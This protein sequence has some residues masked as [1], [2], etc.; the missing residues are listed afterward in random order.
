[1]RDVVD[2]P[3][4]GEDVVFATQER[5]RVAALR[6]AQQASDDEGRFEAICVATHFWQAQISQVQKL[7]DE[8]GGRSKFDPDYLPF[9]AWI[10]EWMAQ[11]FTGVADRQNDLVET[12]GRDRAQRIADERVTPRIEDVMDDIKEQLRQ[13]IRDAEAEVDS[14]TADELA[15][16]AD[17]DTKV[18]PDCAE[19]VKAKARKCRFCGFRFDEASS[20]G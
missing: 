14:S 1:M 11:D 5:A 9:S 16:P 6:E 17:A 10:E 8:A 7:L 4:A 3:I 15:A 13:T 12:L 2:V 18:C 19:E 20:P